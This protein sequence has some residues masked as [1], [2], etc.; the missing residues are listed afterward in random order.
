M[1]KLSFKP[2]FLA[3]Q[4]KWIQGFQEVKVSF[5]R[6]DVGF[7][8]VG[9]V[10]CLETH[11]FFFWEAQFSTYFAMGYGCVLAFSIFLHPIPSQDTS[12]KKTRIIALNNLTTASAYKT[13]PY[14][15]GTI[16]LPKQLTTQTRGIIVHLSFQLSTRDTFKDSKRGSATV[17]RQQGGL[18][19]IQGEHHMI[20]SCNGIQLRDAPAMKSHSI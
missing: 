3:P 17:F 5:Q 10:G 20:C 1:G 4:R 12:S 15:P 18:T 6:M 16:M 13:C 7:Y 19:V 14:R 9:Q 11:R 8:L 2:E